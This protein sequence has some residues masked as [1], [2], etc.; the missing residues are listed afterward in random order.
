MTGLQRPTKCRTCLGPLHT[1]TSVIWLSGEMRST[2]SQ[3]HSRVLG[4]ETN[5]HHLEGQGAIWIGSQESRRASFRV[6]VIQPTQE[7]WR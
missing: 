6:W 2:K 4:R 5:T 3:K 7:A 1:Q